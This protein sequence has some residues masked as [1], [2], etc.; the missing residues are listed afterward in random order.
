MMG[1]EDGKG[2]PFGAWSLF[3]QANDSTSEAKTYIIVLPLIIYTEFRKAV[4]RRRSLL[5]LCTYPSDGIKSQTGR[6]NPP[7]FR[8]QIA[9]KMG[10]MVQSCCVSLPECI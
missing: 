1:Q 4:I 10:W 8:R 5:T 6:E 3:S 7:V 2:R 9:I